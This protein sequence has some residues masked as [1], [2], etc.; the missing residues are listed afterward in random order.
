MLL[1]IAV[2]MASCAGGSRPVR[3]PVVQRDATI[4]PEREDSEQIE[5][6]ERKHTDPWKH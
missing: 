3:E 2:F 6:T 4:V 5:R 1:A